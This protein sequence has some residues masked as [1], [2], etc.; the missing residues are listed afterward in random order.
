VSGLED[1]RA[2]VRAQLEPL[3]EHDLRGFLAELARRSLE[4]VELPLAVFLA[5][6]AQQREQAAAAETPADPGSSRDMLALLLALEAGDD[7]TVQL[8]RD[9]ADHWPMLRW[10]V[11]AL[12]A[13]LQDLG[14]DPSDWARAMIAYSVQEEAGRCPPGASG[15]VTGCPCVL[16]SWESSSPEAGRVQPDPRDWP[17]GAWRSRRAWPDR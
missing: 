7:D 15:P 4:A 3:S 1:R 14:D 10:S 9:R 13:Q 8:I 2:A 17:P 11:S 6:R 12:C 16:C 5:E